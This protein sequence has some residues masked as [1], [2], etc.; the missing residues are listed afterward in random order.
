MSEQSD[1]ELMEAVK[2][3][4]EATGKNEEW[5]SKSLCVSKMTIKVWGDGSVPIPAEDRA[6]L[7]AYIADM[8]GGMYPVPKE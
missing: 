1:A 8:P 7:E 5:L 6:I 4:M 2:N 3:K